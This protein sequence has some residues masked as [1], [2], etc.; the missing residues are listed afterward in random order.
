MLT[1][2]IWSRPAR[3]RPHRPAATPRAFAQSADVVQESVHRDLKK[4]K[5]TVDRADGPRAGE[6]I[7]PPGPKRPTR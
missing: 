6:R 4:E 3:V 2:R 5:G 1:F 7:A